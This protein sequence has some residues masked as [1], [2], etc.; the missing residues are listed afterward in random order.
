LLFVKIFTQICRV[1]KPAA[2]QPS[3]PLKV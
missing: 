1:P 2:R 3:T